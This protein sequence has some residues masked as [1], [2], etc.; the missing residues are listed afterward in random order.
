MDLLKYILNKKYIKIG[1]LLK[2]HTLKV[3][4]QS[5]SHTIIYFLL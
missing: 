2:T 5:S 4:D 1:S 3:E